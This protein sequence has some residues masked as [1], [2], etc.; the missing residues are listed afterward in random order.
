MGKHEGWARPSTGFLPNG[1][2]RS[3]DAYVGEELNLERWS[4]VEERTRELIGCI[5]PNLPSEK[6]RKK[7]SDY[8][9]HLIMKCFPCQVFTFGSVPLKTYLPDGDIDLTIF[10]NN[11]NLKDTWAQQV[12][13][14]LEGE[15]KNE[16]AEFRVKEVQYIQAEVKIIKCLIENIV[17]DI[18]FNQ[19]GGLC[20]LCFLDEVDNLIKQDHL[21]KRSI[22]LIKA[23]CYYESRILGAHHGLISTYALETLV[24]YIFHVFNKKFLGPLEVLYRFLEFFSKFDWDNFCLS[25]WGPV[26]LRSLP[27]ITAESPRKDGGDL[28]ISKKFLDDCSAAY[29]DSPGGQETQGQPFVSKHLNVIDPLRVNNNLGRSVN[30]GNFF[31]IRS[32]FA[33]GAKRLAKLLDCPKDHLLHEIDEFFINTWDRHRS[34]HR[35]DTQRDDLRFSRLSNTETLHGCQNLQSSSSSSGHGPQAEA[36]HGSLGNHHSERRSTHEFISQAQQ[37][38]GNSYNPRM[39]YSI[40]ET[41]SKQDDEMKKYQ[42]NSRVDNLVTE[43]QGTYPF[44]R[45]QSSP[46]LT[47]IY[48]ESSSQGRHSRGPEGWKNQLNCSRLDN[49]RKNLETEMVRLDVPSSPDDSSFRRHIPLQQSIDATFVDSSSVSNCYQEDDSQ[50]GVEG[51]EFASGTHGLMNTMASPYGF[52]DQ[53]HMPANLN[54]VATGYGQRNL[55]GMAPSNIPMIETLWGSNMPFTNGLVPPQFAHYFSSL[56][57]SSSAEDSMDSRDQNFSSVGPNTSEAD[58]TFWHDQDQGPTRGSDLDNGNFKALHADDQHQQSTA[59]SNKFFPS[60]RI[61]SLGRYHS[62][63]G[64]TRENHITDQNEYSDAFHPNGGE[65]EV[66]SRSIQSSYSS[67]IRSKTSSESSWDGSSAKVSR[68]SREKRG[69]KVSSAV[70]STEYGKEKTLSEYP[71]APTEDGI[72]DWNPAMVAT[73]R[74]STGL[75]SITSMQVTAQHPMAGFQPAHP[76]VLDSV[77]Q[78]GPVLLG[79]GSQQ[80]SGDNSVP[81]AFYPTGPPVPFLAMLPIYNLTHDTSNSET[82]ARQFNSDQLDHSD[83]SQNLDS[84]GRVNHLEEIDVPN[85]SLEHVTAPPGDLSEPKSDILDGDFLSHLHNLHY[86]RF[87]QNTP[88]LV[89]P[90]PGVLPPVYLQGRVPWDGYPARPLSGNMNFSQLVSYGSPHIVPVAPFQPVSNGPSSIYHVDEMPRYRSGTGTYLPNHNV[91]VWERHSSNTRRA[92]YGFDRSDNYSERESNWNA[93]QKSRTSGRGY[94]RNQVDKPSPR[95]ERGASHDSQSERPWSSSH[96]HNSYHH[97]QNSPVWSSATQGGPSNV[98]QYGMGRTPA[99]NSNIV[100]SNGPSFQ[101]VV[102]LYSYNHNHGHLHPGSLAAEQFEFGSLGSVSFQALNDMSQLTDGSLQSSG[103]LQEEQMFHGG[104]ASHSSHD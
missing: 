20:T 35:P 77:T 39:N 48:S 33:F 92:N 23:W 38:H 6:Q 101:P 21:F 34:G 43:I 61:S 72:R 57:S 69:K 18:S 29:A 45:T 91:P 60:S 81:F 50:S 75:Q 82:S 53:I 1:L 4:K 68:S 104:P 52:N 25:L 98:A 65:N 90:S 103:P 87:C 64:S 41:S 66:H 100:S 54:L 49:R 31:R 79:P 97:P 36:N 94:N 55:A 17:V 37:N 40:K 15:E 59:T 78:L 24:L 7:V 73:E 19:I 62:H 32:A 46:E 86:G 8:A 95:R 26:P 28:L 70:S 14:I 99:V 30:R 12:R 47:D 22:I 74:T 2:L 96:R 80:K 71:S 13:D 10:S 93:G 85:N 83:S 63:P 16:N 44:A 42:R 88:P 27:D 51:Q 76:G 3:K 67:S 89:Y 9:K 58:N 11:Q 56:C 5:K 84:S 102:M